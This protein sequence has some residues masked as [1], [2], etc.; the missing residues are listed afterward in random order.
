M[1]DP[2]Y[3]KTFTAT[4]CLPGIRIIETQA[5]RQPLVYDVQRDA[6]NVR[7]ACR[8]NHNAYAVAIEDSVALVHAIGRIN[9]IAK[10]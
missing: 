9:A 5:S 8:V 1:S 2:S 7:Q 3:A 6:L 10:A 4:A